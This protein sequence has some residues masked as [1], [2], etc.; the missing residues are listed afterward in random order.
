V[1]APVAFRC[2]IPGC[3]YRTYFFLGAGV[4]LSLNVH[5]ERYE[6]LRIEHPNHPATTPVTW[7][8]AA[9]ER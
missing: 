5:A 8:P 1:V 3:Q 4:G 9:S 6:T 2:P 7:P